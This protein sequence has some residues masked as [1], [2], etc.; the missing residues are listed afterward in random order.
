V[1]LKKIVK[2]AYVKEGDDWGT[3]FGMENVIHI[4]RIDN[5][6]LEVWYTEVQVKGKIKN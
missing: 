5:N 1:T 6:Q 3:S 2:V 4:E